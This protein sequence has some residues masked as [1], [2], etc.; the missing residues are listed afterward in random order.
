MV[1]AMEFILRQEGRS[2]GIGFKGAIINR[3][4]WVHRSKSLP[5]GFSLSPKG[6]LVMS[7]SLP[8]DDSASF[9]M[10]FSLRLMKGETKTPPLV[11]VCSQ[12]SLLARKV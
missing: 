2:R 11:A 10:I 6:R 7:M 8:P 4:P 1:W 5:Y 12:R 9:L 3:R